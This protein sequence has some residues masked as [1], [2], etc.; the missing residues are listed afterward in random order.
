MPAA[1][2]TLRVI[3]GLFNAS[4]CLSSRY[5][6]GFSVSQWYEINRLE[7]VVSRRCQLRSSLARSLRSFR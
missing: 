4:E 2:F 1:M 7:D 3:T 5:F 6:N